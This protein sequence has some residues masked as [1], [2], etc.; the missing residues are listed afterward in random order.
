MLPNPAMFEID[1]TVFGVVTTD[2][3]KHLSGAEVKLGAAAPDRIS[4]LVAHLLAQH[5]Y[6]SASVP[7]VC[8]WYCVEL[9]ICI[10]FE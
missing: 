6:S 8:S 4:C 5:R 9:G 10:P 2:I 1:G 7:T 3:I